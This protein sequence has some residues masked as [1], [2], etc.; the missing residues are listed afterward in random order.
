MAKVTEN[1]DIFE[2]PIPLYVNAVTSSSESD[3][4]A[5]G[6]HYKDYIKIS[7]SKDVASEFKQFDRLYIGRVPEI[8]E[9]VDEITGE[10]VYHWDKLAKTADFTVDS[11][12]IAL[13]DVKIIAK[14]VG[15]KTNG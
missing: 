8:S 14:R 10:T 11:V 9:S 13:D 15:A 2:L 5:F 6:E 7:V 1:R 4:Q 3:I 12:P